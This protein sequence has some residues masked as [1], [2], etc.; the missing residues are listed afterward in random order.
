MTEY[1]PTTSEIEVAWLASPGHRTH[2]G[3]RKEM[4]DRWL[5]GYRREV[6]AGEIERLA[7]S[8]MFGS[9]AQYQL[10]RAAKRIR[11]GS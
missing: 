3:H 11:E 2:P 8:G 7:Y 6:A 9:N 4:F 1:T 5:E 10:L